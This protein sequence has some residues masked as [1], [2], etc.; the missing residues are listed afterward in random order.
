M[1]DATWNA[2]FKLPGEVTAGIRGLQVVLLLVL[3]RALSALNPWTFKTSMF[4]KRALQCWYQLRSSSVPGSPLEYSVLWGCQ[5][6]TPAGHAEP[7]HGEPFSTH[8]PPE[9]LRA[10]V[11]CTWTQEIELLRSGTWYRHGVLPCTLNKVQYPRICKLL[12]R[13]LNHLVVQKAA[14]Q[15]LS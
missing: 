12:L 3:A 10:K 9:R 14:D 11:P 4:S 7:L 1:V 8:R 15:T 5:D 2:G 13:E 6:T